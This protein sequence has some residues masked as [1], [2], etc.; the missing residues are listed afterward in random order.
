MNE[1]RKLLDIE[2]NRDRFVK[3]G[4][5]FIAESTKKE[6]KES[7]EKMTNIIS[8]FSLFGEK[9]PPGVGEIYNLF[10]KIAPTGMDKL[11]ENFDS[12]G[13]IRRLAWS[14]SY[15]EAD[16][17][18]V[19]D[20]EYFMPALSL[21]NENFKLS[22]IPGLFNA[23]LKNWMHPNAG[24]LQTII[25]E[26]T[27]TEDIRRN[28][29]LRLKEKSQ[30]YLCR[31]GAV[32]LCRDLA[33]NN[34][35]LDEVFSF[36]ELPSLMVTYEYFSELAEK[37][38]E[39]ISEQP[40]FPEKIYSIFS[41]LEKHKSKNTNKKCVGK[42]ISITDSSGSNESNKMKIIKFC[43][44]NIGDPAYEF[45]WNPW[46][47]ASRA[48]Q[49]ELEKSRKILNR[50]LAEK[51]IYLFFERISVH[52]DR[53]DFWN[54]YIDHVSNFK[55]YM[56]KNQLNYFASYDDMDPKILNSKLGILKSG[57]NTSAFVMEIGNYS[58]VEFS[59]TG[60]ACYIYKDTN[61]F[62]PELSEQ[63][64]TLGR[65]KHESNTQMAVSSRSVFNDEGR[66]FHS[67]NW[68][69]RLSSW[70]SRYLNIQASG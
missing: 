33:D 43:F 45:N 38:T 50:W 8:R 21:I 61:E 32:N 49:E 51:F 66:I 17:P 19:V 55:I 37:Y 36:L 48:E 35:E 39:T 10:M 11:K 47:G 65:L 62:R 3:S 40:D 53:K 18:S 67:G 54:N 27:E 9:E 28:S 2:F 63:I 59:E 25:S 42:I 22:M 16:M 1:I 68:Q 41:F 15:S 26:Q 57:G 46:P 60:G 69:A 58:F 7:S 14:L 44:Q 29:V 4:K 5:D 64:V 30:Y 6:I 12:P 23:L 52:P 31:G 13:K 34:L 24:W 20:S 56:K 70:I